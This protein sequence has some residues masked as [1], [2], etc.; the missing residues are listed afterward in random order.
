MTKKVEKT[1]V[2][3]AKD[4][5]LCLWKCYTNIYDIFCTHETFMLMHTTTKT[6]FYDVDFTS[7]DKNRLR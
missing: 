3:H 6:T 4:N 2:K 7:V 1:S 5:D